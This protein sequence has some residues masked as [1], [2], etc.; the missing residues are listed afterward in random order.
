[1]SN[2]VTIDHV[3][4]NY[5]PIP[6]LNDVCLNMESGRIIGLLGP[7]GC[8]KTTLMKTMAGLICDYRGTVTIDGNEPGPATKAAVSYLPEKT[9]LPEW[10]TPEQAIDYFGDFYA[11]FDKVKAKEMI[12]RFQLNMKQRSKTMSKGMQEKLQLTLVMCRKARLYLLDE[13]LGGVDPAT[14]SALLDTILN[15]YSEDATLLISTHL[16]YDVERI[17]DSI[18]ML[19]YGRVIMNDTVDEIRQKTGKSIDEVFREVFRC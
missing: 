10:M 3:T 7:N 8:G 18:I 9:Y 11:D 13:P 12:N 6:V 5:G 2:L 1:M 16:I 4:K 15:N 17:F 14:R 19:G